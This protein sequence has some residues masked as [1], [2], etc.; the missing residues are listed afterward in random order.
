MVDM[1]PSLLTLLSGCVCP[2]REQHNRGWHVPVTFDYQ[3]VRVFILWVAQ[4]SLLTCSWRHFRLSASAYFHFMSSRIM[5]DMFPPLLRL[6][7]C[8]F[9]FHEEHNHGWHV[10]VIFGSQWVCT[11]ISWATQS[12]LTCSRHFRLSGSA[13][14]HFMSNKIMADI[15]LPLSTLSQCVFPFHK[16][17]IIA[18]MFPSLSTLRY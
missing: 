17:P 13:C 11:S 2:F 8:V 10:P 12:W 1:F 4:W 6:R 3:R 18:D 14:F 7:L 9:P 5:T 16:Q 15:F